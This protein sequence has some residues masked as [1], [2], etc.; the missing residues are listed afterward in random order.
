MAS[1]VEGGWVA[2]DLPCRLILAV[3]LAGWRVAYRGVADAHV[4]TIQPPCSSSGSCC[5]SRTGDAA[6]Q[7]GTFLPHS[8]RLLA[9]S[10]QL[11]AGGVLGSAAG[12]N[13]RAASE[14]P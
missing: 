12:P 8:R 13:C 14:L 5:C 4:P 3:R 6:Q 1:R 10:D 11:L 9:V 7:Q 2:A